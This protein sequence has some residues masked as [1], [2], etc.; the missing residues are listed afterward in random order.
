MNPTDKNQKIIK[1]LWGNM[2]RESAE[3]KLYQ[4]NFDTIEN[5]EIRKALTRLIFESAIHSAKFRRAVCELMSE[6]HTFEE[7][8]HIELKGKDLDKM[9]KIS[10]NWEIETRE[11]YK[12]QALENDNP[13]IKELLL[14][15][16]E[17]E[18][19]HE[20]IIKNLIQKLK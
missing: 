7:K 16:A 18:E 19:E 8:P 4:H 1:M 3:V 17:Q 5:S 2:E 12:K 20:K 14:Q 10:L 15:I 9:L 6:A 11:L 13:K